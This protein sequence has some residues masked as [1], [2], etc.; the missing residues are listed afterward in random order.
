[1][2]SVRMTAAEQKRQRRQER[3]LRLTS[4]P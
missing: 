1:V 3:N 4:K 2:Q